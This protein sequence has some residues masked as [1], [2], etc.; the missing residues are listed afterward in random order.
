[1][2]QDDYFMIMEH[3]RY[4]LLWLYFCLQISGSITGTLFNKSAVQERGFAPSGTRNDE[5]LIIFIF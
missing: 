3:N 5:F 1:M 2:M 4:I